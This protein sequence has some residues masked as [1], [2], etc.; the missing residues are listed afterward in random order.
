MLESSQDLADRQPE[1]E[2]LFRSNWRENDFQ[3][4]LGFIRH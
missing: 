2:W 4:R 1:T 3:K